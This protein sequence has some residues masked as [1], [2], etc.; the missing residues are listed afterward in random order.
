MA[1][2]ARVLVADG[3]GWAAQKVEQ[4]I[5]SWGY[6]VVGVVR[7]SRAALE[8]AQRRPLDLAILDLPLPGDGLTAVRQF[9]H[10]LGIAVILT[11]EVR[12][13][14]ALAEALNVRAPVLRKPV[15]LLDLKATLLWALEGEAGAPEPVA[16]RAS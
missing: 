7:S 12:G 8:L 2:R 16:A 13:M 11:S 3:D 5:R 14:P 1:R 9:T 10:R 15:Q 4:A 6:E